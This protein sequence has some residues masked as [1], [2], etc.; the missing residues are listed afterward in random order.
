MRGLL[1]GIVLLG[2]IVVAFGFYRGWFHLSTENADQKSNVTFSVDRDKVNKDEE[3]LK[4]KAHDLEHKVM[5]KTGG[6]T[7]KSE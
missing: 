4:D 3:K 1:A 6:P 5:D 2:V 7:G